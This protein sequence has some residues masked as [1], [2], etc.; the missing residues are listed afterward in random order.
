MT[1]ARVTAT[2][3]LRT[4]TLLLLATLAGGALPAAARQPAPAA[5]ASAKLP[6]GEMLA[7]EDFVTSTPA[8]TAAETA[9]RAGKLTPRPSHAELKAVW[10]GPGTWSQDI[11]RGGGWFSGFKSSEEYGDPEFVPPNMVP[12]KPEPLKVYKNIRREMGKGRQIF[13]P[14]TQCHPAGMPYILSM[15]GYG[16]YEAVVSDDEIDMFWGNQR[17]WRRIYL[18][19][20]KHPDERTTTPLYNGFS[21]AHWEGKTMVVETTNIRGS[22]TQIEPHIPKAEGSYIIERYTPVAPGKIALEMTMRNPDFTR[23]WVV[24]LML[25]RDPKGR[26]VEGLCSDDNRWVFRDGELVLTGPNG[27]PLEKAEP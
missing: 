16:G 2:N 6:M 27:E 24:K 3:P 11:G 18:D 7:R 19:G 21:V 14:Y 5:D 15:S 1:R 20:R 8:R 23:P 10:E 9:R 25:T 13:G 26:L 17:E 22:N 12:L 4:A